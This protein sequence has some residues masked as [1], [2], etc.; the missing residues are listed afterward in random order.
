MKNTRSKFSVATYTFFL[1][2]LSSYTTFVSAE[3]VGKQLPAFTLNDAQENKQVLNTDV[4]R[5][6]ASTDRDAGEI[7]A[8]AFTE[9]GQAA[10]D[11]QN[12]IVIADISEVPWFIKGVIRSKLKERS[13]N[14]WVDEDEVTSALIP[15]QEDQV[16]LI[17]L[18]AM[19]I[20]AIRYFSDSASLK[21]ALS[22]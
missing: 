15:Y 17:E 5:I 18:Q 3:S 16:T 4:A 10:L 11:A 14:T 1:L 2:T 7:L 20:H 22:E 8:D 13:F 21:K 9:G 6:Y 19:K 12:A